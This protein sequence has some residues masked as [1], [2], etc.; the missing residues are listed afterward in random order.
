MT[1]VE[2]NYEKIRVLFNTGV[3]T[4]LPKHE[5][6]DKLIS[7]LYSEEE[8]LIV[9]KSFNNVREYLTIDQISER[10]GVTDKEKLQTILDHMVYIETLMK[11]ED[12][13]YF[14]IPYLPGIFETYFTASRDTPEKLKEAGKAHRGLRAIGFHREAYD[15]ISP[16]T[17]FNSESNWRFVPTIEPVLGTIEINKNLEIKNEILTYEI[18]AQHWSKFEVFSESPCSCREVGKLAD[19]PCKRTTE[20]FCMQAGDVAKHMIKNGT[21]KQLTYGQAMERFKMAEKHGLIHSTGNRE[22]PSNFI[23]NCCPCCCMPLAPVVKGYREGVTKS[24]FDPI[25]NHEECILCNTCVDICP[26]ETIESIGE[27]IV[28][29]L[30]YCLGCGVCAANCDQGAISLEKVRSQTPQPSEEKITS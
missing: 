27:K 8:A 6:T 16:P 28:I 19:D 18:L 9:S 2:E 7:S 3:N 20:N 11:K 29:N 25:I 4:K 1:E 30:D 13:T 15:P 26:M 5:L 22:D 12:G 14:M 21:G 17:S 10:S 23:C 24:N